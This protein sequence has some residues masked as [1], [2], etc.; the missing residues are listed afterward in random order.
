MSQQQWR[1]AAV[2]L[3]IDL[4]PIPVDFWHRR[5]PKRIPRG[6]ILARSVRPW[7]LA[8]KTATVARDPPWCRARTA[9]APSG[10][11]T[12]SILTANDIRAF[13]ISLNLRG[14]PRQVVSAA[15]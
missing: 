10:S 12:R 14:T 7:E 13:I 4:N 15:A 5:F 8:S 1:S 9:A 6:L 11:G 3:V 2:D